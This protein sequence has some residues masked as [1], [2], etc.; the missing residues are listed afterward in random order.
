VWFAS[1]ATPVLI[2]VLLLLAGSP[3]VTANDQSSAASAAVKI[4]N[5]V[6]GLRRSRYP[7]ERQLPGPTVMTFPIRRSAQTACSSPR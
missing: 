7:S 1:L 3:S 5:F 6:L 4:D 2:A